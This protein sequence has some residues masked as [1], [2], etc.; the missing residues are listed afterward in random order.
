M[1]G[2]FHQANLQEALA[3]PSHLA[4]QLVLALGKPDETVKLCDA[5]SENVAYYRANGTH[6]VPKRA[7]EEIIF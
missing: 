2:S 4:P 3:L 6:Y 1:I 7:L 5:K